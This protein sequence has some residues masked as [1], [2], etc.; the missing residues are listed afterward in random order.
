MRIRPRWFTYLLAAVVGVVLVAPTLV[1]VGM[2][3]TAGG[4]LSFPPKGSAFAGTTSSSAHPR[5]WRAC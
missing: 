2:S 3:V 5:G 1:V 4:L